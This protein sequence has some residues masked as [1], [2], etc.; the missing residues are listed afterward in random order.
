M[1][2]IGFVLVAAVGV[3]IG[4]SGIFSS[5]LSAAGHHAMMILILT[6]ALWIFKPF[7]MP[8]S[9][10]GVFMAALLLIA[11]FPASTVFSGFA[12]NALWTLI[13]AL[14][15]GFALRKTGLGRRI[16]C[17]GM[18]SI[19]LSY[20][21]LLVMWAVIGVVLSV[22]TPSI[23]VRVI[24]VTPIALNCVEICELP[25]GSKERS[26]VLIS[27]WAMAIIPGYGWL[28]GSLNGPIMTG[29]Y[30]S[31]P[32]LTP[33]DFSSWFAVSFVPIAFV[34]VLTVLA[35]YFVFRPAV[36][37][38]A[39]KSKFMEIYKGLGKMNA[40][41]K[42]TALVLAACFFLFMTSAKH[43]VPDAAVCMFGLVALVIA[44]VIKADEIS[45]GI[46]WDLI[47]FMGI[48]MGFGA[49]FEHAGITPWMSGKILVLL[50]PVSGSAWILLPV[51]L[52][53]MF[54]WR[55]IDIAVFIPTMAI[56]TGVL[57]DI[58]SAYGMDPLVF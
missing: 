14:F 40:H 25:R 17:F 48:A 36:R 12:G 56:L 24:I 44:G 42:V 2:Y 32:K 21:S 31:N 7:G 26:L 6:V 55:F 53:L 29:L 45:T 30:A 22:L 35:A 43:P 23:T 4:F 10:G 49:I 57:P 11:G 9:I 28:T 41:E 3:W 38:S 46:S 33:P 16:A 58:S 52:F 54:L 1:K 15:F 8:L 19:R 47:V 13:P 37:L 5:D 39:E 20:P 34:T 18:K 51:M 50:E 27:A